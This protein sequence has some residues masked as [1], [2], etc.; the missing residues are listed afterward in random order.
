M[1]VKP[2][3]LSPLLVQVTDSD[4]PRC[5]P[6]IA[7]TTEIIPT[8]YWSHLDYTTFLLFHTPLQA[9]IRRDPSARACCIRLSLQPDK[10]DWY[11]SCPLGLDAHPS[12]CIRRLRRPCGLVPVLFPEACSHDTT[13]SW[14]QC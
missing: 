6:S 1:I 14:L 3:F 10:G 5:Y 12:L 9:S 8:T 7:V 13:L 11:G 4:G 2:G